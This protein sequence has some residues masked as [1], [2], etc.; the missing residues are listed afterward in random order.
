MSDDDSKKWTF[1]IIGLGLGVVV[2][3][4]IFTKEHPLPL[5]ILPLRTL[6]Y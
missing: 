3:R 4:L 1:I 6:Q 2:I 5:N